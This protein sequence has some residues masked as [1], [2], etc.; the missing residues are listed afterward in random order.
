MNAIAV[1][2]A[3]TMGSGIA[4][5]AATHACTVRLIDVNPDVLRHG[6]DA[7]KKNLDRAVE[8]GRMSASD[9]DA[10]SARIHTRGEIG[11]LKDVELAIEAVVEDMAI[12]QRVFRDLEAAAPPSAVLAT[13]T[14]SLSVTKIAEALKDSGRVIGMHFFNPATIM[15]LVEIIAGEK[16]DAAAVQAGFAAATAWGKTAVRAADTPGFI[17]NRVARGYYLEALRLLGEGVAGIDEI[18][19]VC[20][21]HG[22]FKMGPFELMDLVGLDVNLA[23]STSVWQ[24]MERH[25]RFTPHEIQR[26]LVEQGRLGRKTGRGFYAYETGAPPV[27]AYPVDRRS[28]QLSPLLSGAVRAFA[29]RAGARNAGSTEQ[30][31]FARILSAILN[32]AAIALDEGVA[33]REDIDI[34]MQKGTNYPKGPLAWTDEIGPRTVRGLL[35]GLNESTGDKRYAPAKS[36]AD[37]G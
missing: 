13:N 1:I 15:P 11:D 24:Q 30:Y 7:I 2:G 26:K 33:S 34:A 9:R 21:V 3:G 28:F 8:K 10:T 29:E 22:G 12:K 36:F 32:E 23:V 16:S 27:S 37:A 20:R 4:Q 18:D 31:V 19:K 14:S 5:L 25:P 35:K 17:V 6:L